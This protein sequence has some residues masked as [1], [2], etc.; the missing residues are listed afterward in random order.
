MR[1]LLINLPNNVVK[2]GDFKGIF[3]PLGIGY[4]AAA[5]TKAG[6]E[7]KVYDLQYDVI[8]GRFNSNSLI[9][10]F[11]RNYYDVFCAGGVSKG[12]YNFMGRC[13]RKVVFGK[14]Y[15]LDNEAVLFNNPFQQTR[16]VNS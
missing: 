10:I 14:F 5:L 3:S 2:T 12:R 15:F 13:L 11:K 4:I 8:I 1:I 9:E 16:R 7:V 6:H